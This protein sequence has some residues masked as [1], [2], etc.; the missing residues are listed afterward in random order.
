MRLLFLL[1]VAS[2]A[3]VQPQTGGG[4]GGGST[5]PPEGTSMPRV[6]QRTEPEYTK[7][8]LD[9]K[10]E[11]FV[12]LSATITTDGTASDIQ[13]VKGLGLGL[14]EKAIECLKEWRFSPAFRNGEPKPTKASVEIR[15][16][17]PSS[18]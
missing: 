13:L 3:T 9:A 16:K 17:L 8:A 5:Q 2:V 6:L 4:R 14:D 12:V 7:E 15:F 10:L 18:N 1:L 11:G